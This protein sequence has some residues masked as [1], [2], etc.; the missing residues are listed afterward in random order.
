MTLPQAR[1][2]HTNGP[3]TSGHLSQSDKELMR[4]RIQG[5]PLPLC[6]PLNQS[7]CSTD[8]LH[9]GSILADPSV[10]LDCFDPLTSPTVT[11]FRAFILRPSI[12]AI[13]GFLDPRRMSS[14]GLDSHIM[15]PHLC[16]GK[17]RAH[18]VVCTTAVSRRTQMNVVLLG[19]QDPGRESTSSSHHTIS[20][21]L[22]FSIPAS[23]DHC[24]FPRG[25]KN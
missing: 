22:L 6:L 8:C 10:V 15:G 5:K 11:S 17:R 23:T 3:S 20:F 4:R 2:E 13:A 16:A 18:D 19:P 21:I 25:T 9:Q 7:P 14:H 12:C 24:L 1:I